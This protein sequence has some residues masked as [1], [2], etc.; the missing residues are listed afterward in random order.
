MTP[1]RASVFAVIVGAA[2]IAAAA[3]A[4]GGQTTSDIYRTAEAENKVQNATST[5]AALATAIASGQQVNTT[6]QQ[7]TGGQG[8]LAG[9]LR[10]TAAAEA[11]ATAQAGGSQ[12]AAEVTATPTPSA[13]DIKDAPPGEPLTG[14]ITVKIGNGGKYDPD[15]LKI[16]AGTKVTWENTERSAHQSISDPGQAEQWD[17]GN[18]V[19]P[20]GSSETVKFSWSFT[21]PGRFTYTSQAPGDVGIRG[22]IFVVP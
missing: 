5:A 8:G 11:T 20:L 7:A 19:R 16:K 1:F 2:V 10:A 12:P 22:V 18:M 21:R 9:S 13:A 3:A 14:E 6:E 4:C 15:I 17:S